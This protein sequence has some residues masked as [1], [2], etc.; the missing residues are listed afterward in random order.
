M[1][2]KIKYNQHINLVGIEFEGAYSDSFI[3]DLSNIEGG[4]LINDCG[5]DGSVHDEGYLSGRETRTQPLT[6]ARINRVLQLFNKAYILGDYALNSS[7]GLHFHISFTDL[8][9]GWLCNKEFYEA[10]AKMMQTKFKTIWDNRKDNSYCGYN[11]DVSHV[12]QRQTGDRYNMINYCLEEHNT[13]EFRFYGGQHATV[14]GLSKCIQ[15]TIDLIG[16]F[17]SKPQSRQ[18]LIQA[19]RTIKETNPVKLTQDKP[20]LVPITLYH[21]TSG[22]HNHYQFNF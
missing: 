18:F 8:A 7:T 2:T 5:Y 21:V 1:L 9:F 4:D 6:A 19:D 17:C 13:I 11:P 15:A 20:R 14:E 3:D 22:L 16:E 10:F 12:Y